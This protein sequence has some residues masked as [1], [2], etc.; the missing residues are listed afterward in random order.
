[1]NDE[2]SENPFQVGGRYK[3]RK[4]LFTVIS[5]DGD[6]MTIRWDNGEEIT[7]TIASQA[8]ILRNMRICSA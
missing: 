4:G 1:M 8:R 6:N 2:S 3:N 5:L 7:D